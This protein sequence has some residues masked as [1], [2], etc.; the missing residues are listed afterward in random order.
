LSPERPKLISTLASTTEFA[1]RVS[2]HIVEFFFA[3]TTMRSVK[4][5]FAAGAAEC[6]A[7]ILDRLFEPS[8]AAWVT[9]ALADGICIKHGGL[10]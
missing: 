9:A 8:F 5:G 6:V 10:R 1:S 7:P 4:T 3:N 2:L